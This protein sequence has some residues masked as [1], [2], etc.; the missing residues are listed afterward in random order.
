MYR[1][2]ISTIVIVLTKLAKMFLSISGTKSIFYIYKNKG[3]AKLRPPRLEKE[4]E[5]YNYNKKYI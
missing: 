3:I 2:N 5:K 4:H 1:K